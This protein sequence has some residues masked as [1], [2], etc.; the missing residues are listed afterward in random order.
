MGQGFPNITPARVVI[1]VE[2]FNLPS[3]RCREFCKTV[4]TAPDASGV[5]RTEETVEVTPP[6]EC[7]CIPEDLHDVVECTSC[8]AIVCATKHAAMCSRCGLVFC[9]VCLTTVQVDDAPIKL[10]EACRVQVACH[11]L[12]R[13]LKKIWE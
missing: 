13:L 7:S 12:I 11:P 5:Y 8:A 4:V 10:C 2:R 1:H 6:L 9:V 3:G